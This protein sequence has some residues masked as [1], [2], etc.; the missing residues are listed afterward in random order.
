VSRWLLGRAAQVHHYT[1]DYRTSLMTLAGAAAARRLESNLM[2][3]VLFPC[4]LLL[5]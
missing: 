2:L 3:F 5:L 4:E 1:N